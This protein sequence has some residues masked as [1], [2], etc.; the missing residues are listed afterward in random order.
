MY[1]PVTSCKVFFWYSTSYYIFFFYNT[2][3]ST[4]R[5]LPQCVVY[6]KHFL[7]QCVFFSCTF[8]TAYFRFSTMLSTI[9]VLM[10]H[11]YCNMLLSSTFN[12]TVH[13]VLRCIF[14]HSTFPIKVTPCTTIHLLTRYIISYTTF[15]TT[16][17]FL[18][19]CFLPQCVSYY[20]TLS[21]QFPVFTQTFPGYLCWFKSFWLHLTV[22][23]RSGTRPQG[24][25]TTREK[26]RLGTRACECLIFF[27]FLLLFFNV[28]RGFASVVMS[29][30]EYITAAGCYNL[31]FCSSGKLR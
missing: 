16:M 2:I 19:V 27:F 22:N 1:T 18:Q 12:R 10:Y 15:F 9:H 11:F 14:Q 7:L 24:V 17:L 6:K 5:C 25:Y 13:F 29:F 20:K 23:S 3:S 30:C 21:V 28:L 31:V 26:R 8:P 4:V